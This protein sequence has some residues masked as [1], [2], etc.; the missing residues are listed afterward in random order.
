M[1]GKPVSKVK[2]QVSLRH[3]VKFAI[4]ALAFLKLATPGG[5]LISS[6]DADWRKKAVSWYDSTRSMLNSALMS[7]PPAFALK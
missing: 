4:P 6:G 7:S 1:A 2:D 5:R 3:I